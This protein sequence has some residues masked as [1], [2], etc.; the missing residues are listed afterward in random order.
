MKKFLG[1]ILA[2]LM[3]LSLTACGE[4]VEE[5]K[6]KSFTGGAYDEYIKIVSA[7]NR[8]INNAKSHSTNDNFKNEL[9]TW[10]MLNDQILLVMPILDLGQSTEGKS[11]IYSTENFSTDKLKNIE[12]FQLVQNPHASSDSNYTYV[13]EC[14]ETK[15]NYSAI[16]NWNEAS[17]QNEFKI[18]MTYS[19]RDI[20]QQSIFY[21]IRFNKSSSY[22]FFQISEA[23]NSQSYE[24]VEYYALDGEIFIA[25]NNSVTLSSSTPSYRTSDLYVSEYNGKLKTGNV[26]SLVLLKDL[27][28]I[29][30]KTFAKITDDE[31]L[32]TLKKYAYA[33]ENGT[34]EEDSTVKGN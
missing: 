10:Q 12:L 20:S 21:T 2:A 34:L 14:N 30:A 6:T 18:S 1:V 3:M 27:E 9:S 23:E 31:R 15:I 5:F 13:M 26:K 11:E 17:G 25:R 22:F 7:Q 33:Y 8:F 24:R 19:D 4:T 29:S 16:V 32:A 28:N